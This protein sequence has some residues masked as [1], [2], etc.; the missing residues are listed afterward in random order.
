MVDL[1][2]ETKWHYKLNFIE[3][4]IDSAKDFIESES[5]VF[6][7]LKR[8]YSSPIENF[9]HL[10]ELVSL[11]A[12][13]D[14][15]EKELKKYIQENQQTELEQLNEMELEIKGWSIPK[16]L[17]LLNE[18]GLLDYMKSQTHRG[19]SDLNL[20]S[21]LAFL[22]DGGQSHIASCL[23][24]IHQGRK[25]DPYKVENNVQSVRDL[26]LEKGFKLPR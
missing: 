25:Q 24:A 23:S 3:R 19:I 7:T 15:L 9:H 20:A 18:L 5:S 14:W 26:L 16:K 8:E 11:R 12:Y 17:I 2:E 22:T 1:G 10:E 13:K 4:E 21:V 6:N